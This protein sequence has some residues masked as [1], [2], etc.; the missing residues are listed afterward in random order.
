MT[1][2]DR[3]VFEEARR[4][5]ELPSLRVWLAWCREQRR[6]AGLLG[7]PEGPGR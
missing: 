4:V 2:R 3:E 5:G 6:N 1:E 7:D